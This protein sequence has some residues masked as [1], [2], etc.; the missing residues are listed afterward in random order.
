MKTEK[1]S[2]SLLSWVL[3]C[4]KIRFEFIS[5]KISIVFKINKFEYVNNFDNEIKRY[6][7]VVGNRAEDKYGEIKLKINLHTFIHLAKIKAFESG[8]FIQ[9][10]SKSVYVFYDQQNDQSFNKK[11]FDEY[12]YSKIP[13]DNREILIALEWVNDQIKEG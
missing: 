9:Q 4:E 5:D 12:H 7:Q 11:S 10:N 2:N 13:F 6:I 8:Y 1:I 3:G